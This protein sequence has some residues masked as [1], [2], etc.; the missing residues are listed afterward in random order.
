MAASGWRQARRSARRPSWRCRGRARPRAGLW[1]ALVGSF[2]VDAPMPER[3]RRP[4]RRFRRPRSRRRRRR[5]RRRR[6]R[7]HPPPRSASPDP[8]PPP[9]LAAPP[10]EPSPPPP[11]PVV[12]CMAS[13]VGEN[14]AA[15]Y[16]INGVAT[17]RGAAVHFLGVRNHPMRLPTARSLVRATQRRERQYTTA[18]RTTMGRRLRLFRVRGGVGGRVSV[19]GPRQHEPGSAEVDGA[20]SVLKGVYEIRLKRV[21]LG[22]PPPARARAVQSTPAQ[23]KSRCRPQRTHGD[24]YS[25]RKVLYLSEL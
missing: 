15:N 23:C 22:T 9:R 7:R 18:M 4:R 3:R 19:R 21:C 13:S 10:I 25:G 2:Y 11:S 8:P 17:W 12:N 20:R 24:Q 14:N 6:P 16:L 1:D 5:R